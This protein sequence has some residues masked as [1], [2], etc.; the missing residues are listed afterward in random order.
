MIIVSGT[1]LVCCFLGSMPL[2]VDALR[3]NALGCMVVGILSMLVSLT[4][5]PALLFLFG[6]K[7]L[8]ADAS[9]KSFFYGKTCKGSQGKGNTDEKS[10]DAKEGLKEYDYDEE[11]EG[12][13]N[14]RKGW[15]SLG[16]FLLNKRNGVAVLLV[17]TVVI[18]P[19]IVK[20]CQVKSYPDYRMDLPP[21][22]GVY[23][24][25]ESLGKQLRNKYECIKLSSLQ[26]FI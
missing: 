11:D 26:I 9:I 13:V 6:E 10:D 24:T 7:L 21:R 8:R 1:T 3:T 25:I 2:P 4:L 12:T 23:K 22:G 17:L 16:E 15:L 19:F 18:I 5:V 20:A 14:S